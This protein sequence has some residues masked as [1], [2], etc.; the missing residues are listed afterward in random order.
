[1]KFIERLFKPK[2]QSFFLFGPRGTGKSMWVKKY[3]KNALYIDFLKPDVFRSYSARPE[4]LFEVLAANSKIKD[5][6]LDEIQKVPLL[7]SVIHSLIE[8]KRELRFI[9]TG[10]SSRK[11]RKAGADLLA[12]RALKGSFHPFMA[13]EL[14][15]GF[16]LK[17]A[18]DFGM[19]P[20]VWFSNSPDE[21]LKTYHSLYL[22]EEIQ[23]EALVRN[24]SAFSRFLE[25]VSFSHASM[26]NI[27]SVAREC[28]VERKTVEGYLKI[29]EDLLLSFS[30]PIFSKRAKRNLVKHPKFYFFDAG[31]FKGIRPKGPLDRPEEIHGLALEGLVAQHFRAWI[32]YKGNKNRLY[33]WR[34]KNGVEVDF[35][36]YGDDGLFAFE[37]KNSLKVR[38][39]DLKSLEHFKKDYPESKC[40]M[41]YR[42]KERLKIG[43]VLC[44]P[45][46]DFLLALNPSKNISF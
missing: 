27:S 12:G 36:I 29:L 7:L 44:L 18:L 39:L 2:K 35:I 42:G 13:Y 34:T 24:I 8:Q 19:L 6:V 31:V 11:L 3:F 37:V 43:N 41:L 32:D 20:L 17:K 14:G 45:C 38:S 10:S 1:M 16:K 40:F 25:A 4:R 30:V 46:E 22:T 5:I 28:E 9:M 26:I 23:M 33:Y 15:R 21:T